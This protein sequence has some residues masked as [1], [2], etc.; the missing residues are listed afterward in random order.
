ML[1]APLVE[2]LHPT[3]GQGDQAGAHRVHRQQLIQPPHK[4]G[5]SVGIQIRGLTPVIPPDA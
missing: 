3:A 2:A 4:T 1:R 5:R